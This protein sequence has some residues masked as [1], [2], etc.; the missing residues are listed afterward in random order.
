MVVF[1]LWWVPLWWLFWL[2]E[3]VAVLGG[4]YFGVAARALGANLAYTWRTLGAHLA[5]TLAHALWLFWLFVGSASVG[6]MFVV[7]LC[8][9]VLL[10][11]CFCFGG[12]RFV[13]VLI[14]WE[15]CCFGGML[16]RVCCQS[17]WRKPGA[18]L[19]HTWRTPGAYPGARLAVILVALVGDSGSVGIMFVVILLRW[20]VCL[21]RFCFGGCHDG[22]VSALVGAIVVVVL[23]GWECCCFGGMLF[24]GC[25]Q[26]T[27]RKPGAHLAHT[28]RTPGAYPGA[29]LAVILVVNHQN[30]TIACAKVCARCAP[31][32]RQVCARFA[33]SALAATPK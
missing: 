2:D 21:W 5:H 27:W 22:C 26:S 7:I 32:V 8:W 29:R 23:V 18:H 9:W 12:C 1:V 28:W 17:T 24:R 6:S 16:F 30:H 19:A 31:G 15:C 20:V 3:R 25:C 13:V 14:V 33:P 4:C 10:W 11:L